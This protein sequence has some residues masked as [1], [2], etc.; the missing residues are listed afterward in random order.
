LLHE[1]ED[2]AQII[3]ASNAFTGRHE[4]SV[5]DHWLEAFFPTLSKRSRARGKSKALGAGP[6]GRVVNLN[7]GIQP[8]ESL[9]IWPTAAAL[10]SG[11]QGCGEALVVSS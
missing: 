1:L 9:M 6:N 3:H 7:T 4:R 2:F 10:S 11:R 5:C 8:V